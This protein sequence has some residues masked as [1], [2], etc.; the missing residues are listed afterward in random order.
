MSLAGAP[1]LGPDRV[2]DGRAGGHRIPRARHRPVS[3][4]RLV[5]ETIDDICSGFGGARR[6]WWTGADP[7]PRLDQADATARVAVDV[8]RELKFEQYQLHDRR[9]AVRLADEFVDRDGDG[10]EQVDD[11]APVGIARVR[12]RGRVV[13]IA[14]GADRARIERTDLFEDVGGALN[15]RRALADPTC[16]SLHA[17]KNR[18]F[19]RFLAPQL[20]L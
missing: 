20:S 14:R 9:G 17:W 19:A 7:P 8:T 2:R 15:Q 11:R 18:C 12:R 5:S 13:G 10:T 16:D 4:C 1:A 6:S 3:R